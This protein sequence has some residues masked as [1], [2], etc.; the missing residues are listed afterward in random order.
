MR[1]VRLPDHDRGNFVRFL[2]VL[3]L[4]LAGCT[5]SSD[6]SA[7]HA[8]NI[9]AAAEAGRNDVANHASADMGDGNTPAILPTPIASPAPVEPRDPGTPGGL[10]KGGVVS[11]AP[12]T[13]DSAQ[14]AA[15]VVQTYFALLEEGK[16]RQAHTLWDDGGKAS[17]MNEA[18]FAA[19]F[20]KYSE[21]HAQIGAPGEIDAGAGQRYV[22]VPVQIYGRLKAGAAPFHARGDVTL[23]RV[24]DID[25]AT[26]EQKTWH[27]RTISAKPQ[28]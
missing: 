7:N 28:P 16:Y 15:N 20:G 2:L 10:P 9:N 26:A 17:G 13:P 12:F 11:E 27:I 5:P 4:L 1:R 3:P 24:G 18:A 25:G 22:T 21:Y 23:H 19:S 8:V 6:S 14:G